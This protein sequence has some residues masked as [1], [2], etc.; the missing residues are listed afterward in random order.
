MGVSHLD[1]VSEDVVVAY[2]EGYACRFTLAL[3]YLLQHILAV[4]GYAAQVIKF[5][6]YAVGDDAT[7]LYLVVLR[8]GV[9]LARKAITHLRG[10]VDLVGYGVQILH[11]GGLHQRLECLHG[12]KRRFE[13][14]EFARCDASGGHT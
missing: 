3:L 11:V 5:G 13:L 9:Y 2:L 7:L 10:G 8:V 1:I 6:R 14:Y 12:R 4:Q